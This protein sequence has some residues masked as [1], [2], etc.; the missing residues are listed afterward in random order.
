MCR[1]LLWTVQ[2]S[3]RKEPKQM[4]WERRSSWQSNCSCWQSQNRPWIR[5]ECSSFV[6]SSW[7]SVS[8][9]QAG[10]TV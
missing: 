10:A 2:C 4:G 9:E 7:S 6:S 5:Q 1:D 8:R 3:R